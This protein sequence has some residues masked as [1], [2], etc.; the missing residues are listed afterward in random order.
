MLCKMM[1]SPT[2]EAWMA[3][4]HCIKYLYTNRDRGI[5]YRSDGNQK[6]I[7]YSDSSN[8]PDPKDSKAQHGHVLYWMNGP[9]AWTSLKHRHVGCSSFENEYMALAF[10]GGTVMFVTK[11]MQEMGFE[12]AVTYE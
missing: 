8:R 5:R 3:A 12:E 7:G 10:A 1:S 2:E 6:M 11:L 4:M 9:I